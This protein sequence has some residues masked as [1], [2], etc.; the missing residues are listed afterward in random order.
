MSDSTDLATA[1]STEP[2]AA[3]TTDLNAA[4]ADLAAEVVQATNALEGE[5]TTEGPREVDRKSVV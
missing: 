2:A 1:P 3:P 4:L 5:I